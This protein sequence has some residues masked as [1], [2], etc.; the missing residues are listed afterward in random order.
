LPVFDAAAFQMGIRVAVTPARAPNANAYAERFVRSLKEECLDR[1]I[2]IGEGHFRRAV[3][4]FVEHYHLERN[5]QGLDNELISGRPAADVAG[6]I[7]R[8][9]RLGG[10]LSY[11]V[12]AA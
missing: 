12:R 8:H 10:L 1:I 5:H 2:P 9:Q 4:E 7:R 11:Y 6:R 3:A